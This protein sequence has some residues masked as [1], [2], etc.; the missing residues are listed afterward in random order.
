MTTRGATASKQFF[1]AGTTNLN[2]FGDGNSLFD[3]EES[4]N[5]SMIE[6]PNRGRSPKNAGTN[7]TTGFNLN[8][9]QEDTA[10]EEINRSQGTPRE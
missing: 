3:E 8:A 1:A 10:E 6:S 7:L 9:V 5:N 2:D 4:M